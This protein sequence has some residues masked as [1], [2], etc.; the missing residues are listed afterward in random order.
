MFKKLQAHCTIC[1]WRFILSGHLNTSLCTSNSSDMLSTEA[2]PE[3]T[4]KAVFISPLAHSG[5]KKEETAG[6]I[7]QTSSI[8]RLLTL[9]RHLD[10]ISTGQRA[11]N[12]KWNEKGL[13]MKGC[14][15]AWTLLTFTVSHAGP[16][17]VSVVAETWTVL[18]AGLWDICSKY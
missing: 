11:G 8:K 13:A 3:R 7:L 15:Y 6:A 9:I 12:R 4:T 5:R 10:E 17:E 14:Y 18:S 1:Y 2:A 16:Q